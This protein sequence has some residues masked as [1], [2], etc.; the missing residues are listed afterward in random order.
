LKGVL[1]LCL[2]LLLTSAWAQELELHFIDVGQG[3]AVLIRTPDGQNVL[4]DGGRS[5]TT[6]L[7]YLRALRVPSLDVAIASH[8]DADHIGGLPEVLWA[9]RPRFYMESP[10]GADS[11]IYL[12]LQDAANES[13]EQEVEPTSRRL[14]LGR[15]TL[16]VLPPPND[17]ALDRNS[18]SV[19]VIISYGDFRAA[20]TGDAEEAE[21]SWWLENIPELLQNVQ[22]YKS[23]HHGSTNG[24]TLE[25]VTTFGPETVVISVGEDNTYGH[26]EPETLAL[27]QSI[28]ADIY[29]TDLSGTVVVT[30]TADGRYTVNA[31]PSSAPEVVPTEPLEAEPAQGLPFDPSGEDQDCGNFSTQAEAQAFYE[32]AG[33]GDPHGLDGEGDG[34]ACESLP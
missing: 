33:P 25:S 29:R 30:A 2:L 10:V 15:T 4:Y 12:E 34:V 31:Q 23:S 24:D 7:E 9:Y 22:V 21:F 27:Y 13:V 6:V 17:P 16:Q 14:L 19:G 8:A 32:A 28:S 11:E 3:D 5:A 18:N 26:P 1:T 20:L